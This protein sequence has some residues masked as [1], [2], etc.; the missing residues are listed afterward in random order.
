MD[1]KEKLQDL[2]ENFQVTSN[3]DNE[4]DYIDTDINY[5]KKLVTLFESAKFDKL[6]IAIR[7]R[8]LLTLTYSGDNTTAEGTRVIEPYVL[9]T[10]KAG[11]KALRAYQITGNS[12]HP[13]EIPGWRLFLTK[14]IKQM[15]VSDLS[16]TGSRPGYNP[17]GDKGMKSI[18]LHSGKTRKGKKEV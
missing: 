16:F 11:N 10:T 6:R 7:N 3:F 17:T 12:D 5:Q 9:G 4:G 1:Y 15:G 8:K 18:E 13:D 2:K 14:N